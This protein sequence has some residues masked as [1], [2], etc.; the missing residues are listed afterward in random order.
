MP[1]YEWVSPT[2]S[3]DPDI[4]WNNDA[5]AYDGNWATYA[6]ENA[7]DLD[8]EAVPPWSGYYTDYFIF[9]FTDP[10]WIDRIRFLYGSST[11]SDN[12]VCI[13]VWDANALTWVEEIW[14]DNYDGIQYELII[15]AILTDQIRITIGHPSVV[16]EK[17]FYEL[18]VEHVIPDPD[19]PV[20]PNPP[21]VIN[22]VTKTSKTP[23]PIGL[24]ARVRTF[25]RITKLKPVIIG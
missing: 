18:D 16:D 15:P 11:A 10:I 3:I 8:Y 4:K 17:R 13:E 21:E 25:R 6:H 24:G 12:I 5:N 14:N 7:G 23:Q 19:N 20:P 1:T 2:G 9:T 22:T